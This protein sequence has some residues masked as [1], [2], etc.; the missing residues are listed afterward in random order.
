[1]S[2]SA[3][4]EVAVEGFA[5][6]GDVPGLAQG[7]GDMRPPDRAGTR[8]CLHPLPFQRQSEFMQL[9][10]DAPGTLDALAL[11]ALERLLQR[12]MFRLDVVTEDVNFAV[13]IGRG[14]FNRGD[15]DREAL[16]RSHRF[17]D[18]SRGIV[19]GQGNGV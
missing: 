4:A 16:S 5:D 9:R 18:S 11:A 13:V 7:A 17:G 10:N 8:Q 3:I 14:D 15:D 2:R 6:R 12:R 19:I 1:M